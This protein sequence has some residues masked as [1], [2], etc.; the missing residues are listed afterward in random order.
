[1]HIYTTIFSC[2]SQI[3]GS[4][5]H[6]SLCTATFF[7]FHDWK[8]FSLF[9]S[10]FPFF[11]RLEANSTSDSRIPWCMAVEGHKIHP[12]PHPP[13]PPHPMLLCLCLGTSNNSSVLE[14][15][16]HLKG[17]SRPK[18]TYYSW[19][20]DFAFYIRFVISFPLN[21]FQPHHIQ[22][23]SYFTLSWCIASPPLP[24]HALPISLFSPG[25]FICS[26]EPGK[27]TNIQIL[28]FKRISVQ[29]LFSGP[30]Q[31]IFSAWNRE[32][33]EFLL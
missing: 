9:C 10:A 1:M 29:I 15:S 19:S 3:D 24:P 4:L 13:P 20:Y 23:W 6:I 27:L 7:S 11:F 33:G 12:S 16:K 5:R 18:F 31:C 2:I 21:I 30:V 25:S 14:L 26:K 28:Y 8:I 17:W 22:A 32:T